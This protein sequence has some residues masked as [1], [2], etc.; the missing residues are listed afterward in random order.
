ME[1]P[2][3]RCSLILIGQTHLTFLNQHFYVFFHPC[4]IK[5]SLGPLVGLEKTRITSL[6]MV[7]NIVKHLSLEWGLE[8]H[9]NSSFFSVL[10]LA[11]ISKTPTFVV[12]PAILL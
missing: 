1:E 8:E 12:Q 3:S 10:T 2:C 9:H 11:I 6:E 4:P 7:M 5:V